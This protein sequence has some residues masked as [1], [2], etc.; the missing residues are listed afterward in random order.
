MW[1]QFYNL[2][3]KYFF[4]H[5]DILGNEMLWFDSF[6]SGKEN[7]CGINFRHNPKVALVFKGK[8]F[9]SSSDFILSSKLV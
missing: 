9:I 6:Y 5:F 8:T 1:Y 3:L 4:L 7:G 2:Q